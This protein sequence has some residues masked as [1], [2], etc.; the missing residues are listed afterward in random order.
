MTARAR[1]G[2]ASKKRRARA[3]LVISRFWVPDFFPEKNAYFLRKLRGKTIKSSGNTTN[4]T[5]HHGRPKGGRG[6]PPKFVF[7]KTLVKFEI[8][9]GIT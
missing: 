3:L 4:L 5:N 7:D 2:G 6:S 1:R 8:I 9:V